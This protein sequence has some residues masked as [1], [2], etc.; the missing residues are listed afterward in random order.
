MEVF[1]SMITIQNPEIIK[2][3]NKSRL[4]A[5]VDIDD[6]QEILWYEVD[7]EYERYL[8]YER[9]DA[10]LVAVLHYAFRKGHD[11]TCIA[12][13][14]GELFYNLTEYLIPTLCKTAP[15]FHHPQIIAKIAS[16]YLENEGAVGTG[17]SCG[18]DSF[19]AITRHWQP[20]DNKK[21]KLTHV[22][23]FDVGTFNL[24]SPHIY[25]DYDVLLLKKETYRRA[26]EVSFHL[27]L[28]LIEAKSNILGTFTV[29]NHWTFA[30]TYAILCMQKLWKTYLFASSYPYSRFSLENH[31]END[32]SYYD[33]LSM[34]YFSTSRLRIYSE[35]GEVDRVEKTLRIVDF[36]L[37]QKYLLVCW[38]T[39]Y[40]C[41][42]CGKCRRTM[43]TLDM[44]DKLENFKE[45]FPVDYYK[46][47]L[48][49]Y[50]D[51]LGK[52]LFKGELF[53]EDIYT[54]MTKRK[55]KHIGKIEKIVEELKKIESG[56]RKNVEG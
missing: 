8:C 28:P 51:W 55:Y 45:I 36:P 6:V 3:G 50:F 12:P 32:S 53:A 19:H 10:I 56:G 25:R 18:V 47:N 44:F 5:K 7:R 14:S 48:N 22:Q 20:Q 40:N 15:T 35:G 43:L 33:L 38:M 54:Y 21:P 9:S 27:N 1:L 16:E 24:S 2:N 17:I 30:T 49:S 52:A 11:I 34:N 39:P 29:G 46:N 26:R 37:A 41:G 31:A 23:I 4:V 13:V 42:V